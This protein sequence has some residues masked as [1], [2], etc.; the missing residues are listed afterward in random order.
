M[1]GFIADFHFIRPM[2]FF[3]VP[4][5]I[6]LWWLWQQR[7]DTLRGWRMQI[8]PDLLKALLVGRESSLLGPAR[9]VLLVCTPSNPPDRRLSKFRVEKANSYQF[10]N[11]ALHYVGGVPKVVEENG[12]IVSMASADYFGEFARVMP[13]RI[14]GSNP[15][16]DLVCMITN[17]TSGDINN[18]PFKLQRA[19]RAPFEQIHIVANKT[20]DA[21]WR[22]V[23]KIEDYHADPIVATRQREVELTYRQPS[24]AEIS[25]AMDLLK[26]TSKERNAIH[27]RA[28]SVANRTIE[29]S[30]P[31]FFRTEKVI[32][33][34]IRIG[35]Q[36]IVSLPFEVLVE[37]GL[38]IKA[39]SPFNQTMII[40]L[41]N[42]G[43][44]YLPNPKQHKLGGYETWLGTCRFEKDSSEILTRHL[45]AMLQELHT[46]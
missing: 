10:N 18:L 38:D 32:I 36:S 5:V 44:G 37:I 30:A 35:D 6:A 4:V 19:P 15:S 24:E 11:Y 14:G 33:Q 1:R 3:L 39:K 28:N 41:A 31:E 13:Y 16:D 40:E 45:L 2:M 21:A 20:A 9:W 25:R 22:A 34:A 42:G 12:R 23:K 26:L 43:Y 27:K 8:A 46:L 7:S 29:Y 17:G